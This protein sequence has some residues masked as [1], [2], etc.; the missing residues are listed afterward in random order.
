MNEKKVDH[1]IEMERVI[2]WICRHHHFPRIICHHLH[3]IEK[4]SYRLLIDV[5]SI[6]ILYTFG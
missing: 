3:F 5:D 4:A 6:Y 1:K 2:N